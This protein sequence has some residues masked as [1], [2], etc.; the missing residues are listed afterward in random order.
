MGFCK[1][2][3]IGVGRGAGDVI[4]SDIGDE[5]V[6]L[7]FSGTVVWINMSKIK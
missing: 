7:K 4:D 6:E 1:G 2:F 3:G 5:F